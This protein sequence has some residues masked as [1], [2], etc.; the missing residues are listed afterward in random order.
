MVWRRGLTVLGVAILTATTS[1]GAGQAP[2][3]EA[4]PPASRSELA[5]ALLAYRR[6]SQPGADH[7]WLDPLE[8]R[9]Q[10]EIGWTGP[11]GVSRR[12][13]GVA[14]NRWVLG[15]R[16]LLSEATANEDG[17]PV[18]SLS[19]YGY[20]ADQNRFFSL[21]LDNLSTGFL[22]LH[23][24]YDTVARSFILSGRERDEISGVKV[25]YRMRLQVAGPDKHTVEVFMDL[26]TA[27][28]VRIL[29]ATYTRL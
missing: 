6:A 29:E 14:E 4:S 12:V 27:G 28:P 5:E 13:R 1:G 20:D 10:A 3:E 24:T 16:F 21:M 18:E 17:V 25:T 26:S 22:E 19:V 15:G 23:G 9:W 11:D 8:G 2:D 7:R